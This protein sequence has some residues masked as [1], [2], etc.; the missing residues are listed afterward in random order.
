MYGREIVT[1]VNAVSP[2]SNDADAGADV[3]LGADSHTPVWGVQ[4]QLR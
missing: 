4:G 3:V 2:E 1:A